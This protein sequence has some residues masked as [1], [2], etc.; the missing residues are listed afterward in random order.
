MYATLGEKNQ[1]KSTDIYILQKSVDSQYRVVCTVTRL[2]TRQSGVPIPA[3]IQSF[4][5]LQIVQ[6]AY[7]AQPAYY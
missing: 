1:I 3:R 6:T 7:E 2:E 4:S 5:L